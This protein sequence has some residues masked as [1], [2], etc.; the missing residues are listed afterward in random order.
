MLVYASI[1]LWKKYFLDKFYLIYV[2]KKAKFSIENGF[3][4]PNNKSILKLDKDQK[5]FCMTL[6]N[7]E[8]NLK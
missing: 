5:K 1:F 3:V 8:K 7:M 4:Q 6:K 2:P